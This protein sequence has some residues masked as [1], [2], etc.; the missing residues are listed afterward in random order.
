ML[1]QGQSRSQPP[2]RCKVGSG[3]GPE[4]IHFLPFRPHSATSLL[5]HRLFP[6][7]T[8]SF[9][10]CLM[11]LSSYDNTLCLLIYP[12]PC[13]A[14]SFPSS[15]SGASLLCGCRLQTPPRGRARLSS[16]RPALADRSPPF[17]LSSSSSSVLLATFRHIIHPT[18]HQLHSMP[19]ASDNLASPHRCTRPAPGRGLVKGSALSCV[20][21][22]CFP[23]VL[24]PELLY[25]FTRSFTLDFV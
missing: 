4:T 2:G 8:P 13:T 1:D 9:S 17:I 22:L 6:S 20:I 16:H 10:F 23:F 11:S 24:V 3:L 14:P 21:N 12:L 18:V 25:N 7:T 5:S 15:G 19:P